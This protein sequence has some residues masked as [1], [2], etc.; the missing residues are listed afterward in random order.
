MAIRRKRP[1]VVSRRRKFV[2]DPPEPEDVCVS[3]LKT[4]N[5]R[6]VVQR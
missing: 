1:P 4:R 2:K 3:V 6:H 5:S